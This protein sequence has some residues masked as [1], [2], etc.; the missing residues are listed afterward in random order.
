MLKLKFVVVLLIII[1]AIGGDTDACYGSNISGVR[2]KP[3]SLLQR[4]LQRAQD[5]NITLAALLS[6]KI[7]L[8]DAT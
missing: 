4:M 6:P 5:L 8:G 2:R 3:Q 1:L 7:K